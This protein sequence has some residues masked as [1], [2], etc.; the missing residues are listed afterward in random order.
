MLFT[1]AAVRVGLSVVLCVRL[2]MPLQAQ[3]AQGLPILCG[4]EVFNHIVREHYPELHRAFEATFDECRARAVA[5]DV[6]ERSQYVIPVVIHVVWKN[7][8]ENLH[9]SILL[10]QIAVLNEDYNRLNA[11]TGNLRAIFGQV[12]GNAQIRFALDEIRRVKTNANFQLNVLTGD[13][14]ANL[15][16]SAQGGSNAKDPLRYLNI[17]ICRIQPVTILGIPLGQVL[18]FAFPPNNLPNWPANSGAPALGQD[19]VVLDF[20]T[21]G[22]NNPNPLPNPA[23]GGN[24]IIRGRTGTHEVGHYLGLRHIWGDGGLLGN[25]DCNQSDGI[26]DTPFANSQSNFDCNKNRNTCVKVE[27]FYGTDMPDLI[28]NYMDYASENCMNM[29]TRGQVNHMRA[30]L[31]GPRNSLVQSSSIAQP[32]SMDNNPLLYP[33]PVRGQEFWLKIPSDWWPCHFSLYSTDRRLFLERRLEQEPVGT[34]PLV[35]VETT[36]LASG[37]YIAH[38][39]QDQRQWTEKVFIYR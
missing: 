23:G 7:P 1:H 29:F 5:P 39:R 21:V 10:N 38:V 14:M 31:Q 24:L 35:R 17:W 28:E 8:E 18:G 11:D 4:Q 16:N 3:H 20:R 9:D 25:N 27:S 6:Q 15:K 26:D 19:G 36:G 34:L 33:N 37:W 30:V 2:V 12:V 13:L 22:R 32:G